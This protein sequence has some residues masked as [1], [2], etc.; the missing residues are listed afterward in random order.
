MLK[1]VSADEKSISAHRVCGPRS[2]HAETPTWFDRPMRSY[3]LQGIRASPAASGKSSSPPCPLK[4]TGTALPIYL[5]GLGESPS[6]LPSLASLGKRS[7]EKNRNR[8]QTGKHGL[9][10]SD[11]SRCLGQRSTDSES[12]LPHRNHW[13]HV[14]HVSMQPK[15]PKRS[16]AGLASQSISSSRW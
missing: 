9:D 1:S 13:L 11:R 16:L 7:S 4:R 5:I 8:K 15:L 10:R 6:K 14:S 3:L 2:L 12:F